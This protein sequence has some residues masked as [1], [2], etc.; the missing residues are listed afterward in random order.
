[1]RRAQP[2]AGF[3]VTLVAKSSAAGLNPP[4]ARLPRCGCGL[5]FLPPS[6]EEALHVGESRFCF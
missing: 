6:A 4:K 2:A 5:G 1:M 3:S